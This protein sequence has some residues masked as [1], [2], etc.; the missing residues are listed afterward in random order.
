MT[1]R[2][3]SSRSQQTTLTGALTSSGTSMTV[4][5]GTALLGG[6]TISAGETFTVVI[7]PDTAVE[8]IVDVTAVSTN[9]LTIVRGIDGSSGQAHSAG[10]VVRHMA[11]GRDY[12]EANSHIENVTSAHG[13]T[14]ADVTTNAGTQTLT[15]K[16]IS[17][18]SNTLTGVATLTGTQTLTNKTLT[19][20]TINT[21]AIS[22]G[23]ITGLSSPTNSGDAATK[24]YT[25]S[26]LGSAVSAATSA[27]SAAASAT[28]AATS[29]TSAAASA[30]AA[31]TSA[32]SAAA[33]AT[34]AATSATT[35][36]NQATAAAT[37]ATSASAS[38]SAAATS[39]TSAQT[40]ATAAATS[41]TSA[42][43]S[44]T[45]AA[46]SATSAASSAT[47]AA[48]SYS[49]V[50]GL[51]GAGIV[52]DMG[53]ITDADTTTTSYINISAFATAAATSATSAANSA[54]SAAASAAAAATSATSAASSA[55]SA[56]AYDIS[57]QNWATQ[58]GTP[59]AGGEYSAKYHAQAAATSATSAANSA[60]AAATSATSAATSASLAATIVASAV[61][62][63]LIDAKGDLLVGTANDTVARLPVGTNGYLLT[64][65][66]A[67]A[68]GIKWAAAP[69]SL[70][71]QTGQTGKYLTT[72]GSTASWAT[73][74]ADIESVTAGTGLTGGGTSGAV[75]VS[76]DTTSAYVVPSQSGASGKYLTSN[77]T[78]ASWATITTDPL[79]QIMMMMGA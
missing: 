45:A 69:V 36:T 66:S 6:I 5:S 30:T 54:T 39:A 51:T 47:N 18:A 8:E 31:A 12:R 38:A 50:V 1:V 41:A 28:A 53:S 59:V 56:A 43:A 23:T 14:I 11:I 27:T 72:D 24:G 60:T 29:A 65:D 49:S 2:K 15:N 3:Y 17:A 35:A 7:D 64:A 76:L 78:A 61:S 13:L 70:P 63:T 26:I 67:E 19:S 25:D 42:A 52:R 46:T 16:T 73:I 20:P 79:P 62:G 57:A 71:S 44:A 77:G 33:S 4:V 48:N 37:S 22:G 55:S 34:A 75:T 21:P 40:S 74:A 68:S 10:A 9:T 58:L 32:T